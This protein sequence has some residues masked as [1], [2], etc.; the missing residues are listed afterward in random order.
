MSSSQKPLR[1]TCTWHGGPVEDA[2]LIV[3]NE[4]PSGGLP[5]QLYACPDCVER[6]GLKPLGPRA[7]IPVR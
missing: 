5:V 2:A 1:R 4:R 7:E 6:H 3:D